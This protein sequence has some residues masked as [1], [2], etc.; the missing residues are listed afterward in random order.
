MRDIALVVVFVGVLVFVLKRPYVGIYLW[1]WLGFMNPHR[2]TWGFAYYLPFAQVAAIATLLA[3]F[4]T[5]QPVRMPW[6]RET[7]LLLVFILWMLITTFFA[8]Y[9]EHAWEQWNKVWKIMF[10]LYITLIL[11]DTKQKLDWLVWVIVISIGF[12]GVKGGIFT[13]VNGG[14]YRV[15]GPAETFIGGNNEIALALIMTIPLMRYLQLQVDHV[16]LHKGMVVAMLLTGLAAIGTQSRGALLGIL[17]MAAFLWMKSRNR[18]FTLLAILVVVGAV[19]VIMPEAWWE[20]MAS[21][22]NYE[23]DESAT[24]RINAWWT[25]FN[26]AQDR[27]TGGGF[28]TFKTQVFRIYAPNPEEHPDAHSIFF[29][30][31]GEH[32]FIGFAMFMLLGIFTWNTGSRIKRRA[33]QYA[34]TKWAADLASMVQV[35]LVGY[36]APG[37]FLGLAYFDYYYTLIAIMVICK[38]LVFSEI[39][40]FEDATAKKQPGAFG[41]RRGAGSRSGSIADERIA[42]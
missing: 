14:V 11:I 22:Q 42:D 13:I 3:M 37:A 31:M 17:A 28:E 27:I 5:R 23:E 9:P 33:R 36:A 6:T 40:S 24:N 25:A 34:E 2:L 21:I 35:C 1:T 32:G 29:E 26:L 16:W 10:M 38:T 30:V 15:Q 41:F 39:E 19:L 7:V 8:L 20:R 4:A 12:Y 18:A